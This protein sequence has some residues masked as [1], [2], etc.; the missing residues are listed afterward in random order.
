MAKP[1]KS[2]GSNDQ[3]GKPKW[4]ARPTVY[5]GIQMRS[6]L[7]AGFAAWLDRYRFDWEYEPCAFASELGQYLPDFRLN[8]VFAS[9]KEKR[10]SMYVEVK[11][12]SFLVDPGVSS[13]KQEEGPFFDDAITLNENASI[14]AESEPEAVYLLARPGAGFSRVEFDEYLH[15]RWAFDVRPIGLSDHKVGFA[16]SCSLEL[17]WHGEYWRPRKPAAKDASG[18][19]PLI[20]LDGCPSCRPIAAAAGLEPAGWPLPNA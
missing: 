6:R 10:V 17:P 3:T 7:E 13:S 15:L 16:C 11:P 18:P 19:F 5:K 14:L 12:S 2:N 4:K 8:D 1:S 9:W 20:E